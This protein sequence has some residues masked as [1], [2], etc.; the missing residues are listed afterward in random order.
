MSKLPKYI[1]SPSDSDNWFIID[2][3][4]KNIKIDVEKR[5]LT[6][7][8]DCQPHDV[9]ISGSD[10]SVCCSRYCCYMGCYISPLEIKFIED[11]LPEI[12]RY[13]S[14]ESQGVLKQYKDEFYL[15]EDY[16]P[17]ENLYKTR[18]SPHESTR[19]YYDED[20][21]EEEIDEDENEI[22]EMMENNDSADLEDLESTIDE[23]P[24]CS[25]LFLME[26]GLCAVHK[27][28]EDQRI[29][30]TLHKFNICSTFPIDI[31]VTRNQTAKDA[32]YPEEKRVDDECSTLKM[33][34][35]YEDFLYT[36]MN[37]INLSPKIKAQKKV[38]YIL[39]SMKYAIV[40]RFGEEI[41][42]AL[43]EYALQIRH[44]KS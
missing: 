41:W 14:V 6:S 7:R 21:S 37:C 29:D 15:P 13:L 43:K 5:V 27:F 25:C 31:R 28:C 4:D 8:F 32:P 17:E 44:Q 33:M 22:I 23:I 30:W 9:H 2:L 26:D 11:H 40:S 12:K 38:P 10:K 36:H 39:D 19:F 16:D 35:D 3:I 20:V 42:L 34:D 1:V 18:C 24:D